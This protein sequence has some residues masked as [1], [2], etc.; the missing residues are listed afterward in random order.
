[1][2]PRG[3]CVAAAL[4]VAVAGLP[5][6]AVG[7]ISDV[8]LVCEATNGSGSAS[9]AFR[10]SE[11]TWDQNAQ[12]YC[13]TREDPIDLF[14]PISHAWVASLLG[15]EMC[16]ML[17]SANEIELTIGVVSGL[18]NTTFHVHS[19]LVSFRTIPGR[20]S[21]GRAF[22]SVTV[23]DLDGNF[24]L[25]IANGGTGAGMC[26]GSYNGEYPSGTVFSQLVNFVFAS[27]FAT[28]TGS[29]Q[30][31]PFGFRIIGDNVR[32]ISLYQTFRVTP[33]DVA[34]VTMRMSIPEP[35]ARC[36]GDINI[37][38]LVDLSDLSIL[39]S[40]FGTAAG[41]PGYDIDAD[42]DED[43]VIS[44]SDLTLLLAAFGTVCP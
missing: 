7:D 28:V 38:Y 44:V 5:A 39:L 2:V 11:G 13:L 27:A 16:V 4:L 21:M 17:E 25:A 24:A 36:N 34:F 1:M 18:T 10:I 6:I 29:Q 12:V 3:D 26:R 20:D 42:L 30:D 35:T 37:D 19:P 40:T 8:V 32:D 43:G 31:P 15:V 33:N 9:V 14:D 41:Q 22:A 23:T